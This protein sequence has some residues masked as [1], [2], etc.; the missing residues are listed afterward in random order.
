MK[1]AKRLFSVP[2]PGPVGSNASYC[3]MRPKN[4]RAFFCFLHRADE[5][6]SL[7]SRADWQVYPVS[8]SKSGRVL[9]PRTA[10]GRETGTGHQELFASWSRPGAHLQT[11][12]SSGLPA[13]VRLLNVA[14]TQATPKIW[15]PTRRPPDDLPGCQGDARAWI[16]GITRNIS[17]QPATAPRPQ[18]IARRSTRA[19]WKH[20][21]RRSPVDSFPSVKSST[22]MRSAS[23][24]NV[25]Y[26]PG[27]KFFGTPLPPALQRC[28]TK[29]M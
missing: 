29:A 13:L 18:A 26:R 2:E 27:N 7:N 21:G 19:Q 3:R 9:M 25:R 8:L 17:F 23:V 22:R 5:N 11:V 24:R 10:T 15:L 14:H 4:E 16:F 28:L 12:V 6:P 1:T 20:I